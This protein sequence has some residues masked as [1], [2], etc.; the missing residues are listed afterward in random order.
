MCI[1][2]RGR[3]VLAGFVVE[4]L[5]V[6]I[7]QTEQD[8]WQLAGI[9]LANHR[10]TTLEILFDAF[11]RV[12]TLNLHQVV[13][14]IETNLGNTFTLENGSATIENLGESHLLH[15]NANLEQ[16]SDQV[17]F[18]FEVEGDE[19]SEIDGQIYIDIPQSDYSQ[20]VQG[21][22]IGNYGI[23]ELFGGGDFWIT[24]VSYT[25]LTLPTILLV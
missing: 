19:I 24:P 17:A 10:E 5:E 6:N 18:S 16:S 21:Q 9:D 15:I 22:S 8:N 2:D 14:N 20:L 11:Q 3:W 13:I 23:E 7:E 1:R 4:T 25:H 12:S